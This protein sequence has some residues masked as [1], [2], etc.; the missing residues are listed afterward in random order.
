MSVLSVTGGGK[1]K[2]KR[3]INHFYFYFVL[4]K[5]RVG[6]PVKHFIKNKRPNES[7][8]GNLYRHLVDN[9]CLQFYLCKPIDFKYKKFITRCRI[10]ARNLN[11]ET[12]RK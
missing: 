1:N 11:I 5:V 3:K 2:N 10:S 6:S 12:G 7:A 4:L 9:F 8:L